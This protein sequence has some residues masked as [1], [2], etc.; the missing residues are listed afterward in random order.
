MDNHR[1]HKPSSSGDNFTFP[2]MSPDIELESE[3]A[4]HLFSN[5]KFLLHTF[6]LQPRSLT[7]CTFSRTSSISSKDSLVS[8]RS[9][10]TNSRSSTSTS[11]SARSS[12]SEASSIGAAMRTSV[13]PERESRSPVHYCNNYYYLPAQRWQFMAAVPVLNRRS[14]QKRRGQ[15]ERRNGS[16]EKEKC[17]RRKGCCRK[18]FRWLVST[19]KECHAMEPSKNEF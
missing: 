14:S 18:F 17:S 11:S 9:N 15:D 13:F 16:P 12:T 4:D 5:G 7:S 19:C 3:L 8:S 2:A 10:S 6:P 1:R